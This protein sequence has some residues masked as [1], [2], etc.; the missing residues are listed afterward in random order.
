MPACHPR[1]C[2]GARMTPLYPLQAGRAW[3]SLERDAT[4]EWFLSQA[5]EGLG[6]LQAAAEALG[7]SGEGAPWHALG[8][9]ASRYLEL[10]AGVLLES[11]RQ[12]LAN[13]HKVHRGGRAQGRVWG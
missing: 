7:G 5:R 2:P 4:A 1:M 9:A 10:E 8:V 13:R 12:A 6:Q 3:R 11:L